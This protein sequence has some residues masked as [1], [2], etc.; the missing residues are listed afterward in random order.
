MVEKTGMSTYELICVVVPFGQGGN[1][2]QTA[3]AAGVMGGTILLGKGTIKNRLLDFLGLDEERREVVMM[4]ADR[5][6]VRVALSD[7]HKKFKMDKPNRG[8]A[9]TTAVCGL[10]GTRSCNVGNT[11]EERGE[12]RSMYQAIT[13]IVDKGN[14]EKVIEAATKAGSR[15]G[16]VINARG[17]GIHETSKLFSME[18]EPEKEIVLIVSLTEETDLIVSSVREDLQIDEPGKGIIFVQDVTSAWGVEKTS[19]RK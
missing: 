4:V 13:I 16:T 5:Q 19:G 8:I 2:M 18:I 1:V 11:V 9:Y 12:D 17:A 6:T 14:A 10:A 7:I 3:R 15:G